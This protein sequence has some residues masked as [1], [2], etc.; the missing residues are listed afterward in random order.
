MPRPDWRYVRDDQEFVVTPE[1]GGSPWQAR[2]S[3][4]GEAAGE[5]EVTFGV[6]ATGWTVGMKPLQQGD[7]DC[8]RA[9]ESGSSDL[10][11]GRA[12]TVQFPLEVGHDVRSVRGNESQES[13]GDER[14]N[15]G[16]H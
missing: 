1:C 4:R 8:R 10:V 11:C 2:P 3:I 12:S 7:P 5:T 9:Y 15:E 14:A 13:A 6:V 16:A